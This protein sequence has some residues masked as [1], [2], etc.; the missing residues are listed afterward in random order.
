MSYNWLENSFSSK[1]EVLWFFYF[2]FPWWN[3]VDENQLLFQESIFNVFLHF[4]GIYA[5]TQKTG[6]SE[7]PFW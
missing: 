6:D 1:T 5:I 4:I 7:I 2:Y 3:V